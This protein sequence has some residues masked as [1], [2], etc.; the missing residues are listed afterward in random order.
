[1][2]DKLSFYTWKCVCT[3]AESIIRCSSEEICSFS[4][5]YNFQ[6]TWLASIIDTVKRTKGKSRQYSGEVK[7]LLDARANA[8]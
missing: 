4:A 5:G 3:P 8:R 6:L 1:M 2:A 7:H